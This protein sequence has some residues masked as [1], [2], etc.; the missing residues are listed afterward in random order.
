M[1]K[2][3]EAE[4]QYSEVQ[5]ESR[6]RKHTSTISSSSAEATYSEVQ[7]L[8]SDA[9]A[10]LPVSQQGAAE[11]KG[12]AQVRRR[13][14]VLLV[15]SLLLVAAV[16]ALAA[17]LN[18]NAQTKDQLQK[19]QLDLE[20]LKRNLSGEPSLTSEASWEQHEG[21]C[22]SFSSSYSSWFDG[23]RSCRCRGGD[24][25]KIDSSEEQ[26]FLYNQ[27]RQR[28]KYF[29][30]TFWI[31][32]TDSD[33]EGQWSW[34]DGSPLDQSLSLWGRR[35]PDNWNRRILTERTVPG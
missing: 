8:E 32:L 11:L 25:V 10:D 14:V 28:R 17:S 1:V 26:T 7:I 6:V 3:A 9:P 21:W 12:P 16:S 31:G 22:Y 33:T 34:V 29:G 23:R 19:L 30:E 24:L 18:K 20:A 5:I 15:L 4:V 35:Q 2:M 27:V 13:H